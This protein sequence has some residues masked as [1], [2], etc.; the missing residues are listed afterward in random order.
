MNME[1]EI[2]DIDSIILY[3][4]ASSDLNYGT[5]QNLMKTKE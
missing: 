4:R 1:G 2:S 5:M 3:W